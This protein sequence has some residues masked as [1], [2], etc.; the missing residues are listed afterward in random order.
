MRRREALALIAGMIVE[1]S[2]VAGAQGP[3]LPVVGILASA[4]PE[5]AAAQRNI[6]ACREALAE[7]GFVEG[8]TV[9]FEYRW[10]NAD[11]DRVPE[12]VADLVRRKVDVIVTEGATAWAVKQATST[13]P[14]V[15]HTD[16]DPVAAGLIA[17]LARPGGNLTG[18]S[19]HELGG[20][21]IELVIELVP[22]ATAIAVLVNPKSVD[23][24][25]Q[26]RNAQQAA[27]AKHL[28]LN[29]VTASNISDF[30]AAFAT[31]DRSRPDAL[32]VIGD[33]LFSGH[34][35]EIITAVARLQIPTIYNGQ[36]YVERGG[37]M[38]Y[39]TLFVP[40][41]RRKGVLAAKILKGAKPADLPV[42][43][44]DS[45]ELIINLTTAKALGLTVPPALLL[46]VDK[47]IE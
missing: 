43:Q 27:S 42:E 26:L 17:S 2:S 23:A 40:M 24:Q 14:V 34:A 39:G 20:K 22:H 38:S 46:R 5:N 16:A 21:R 44:A 41:Y 25:E 18:I 36:S 4:S 30:D 13:I 12:L 15:F 37:L 6:A 8:R 3:H 33:S 11:L 31:L 1:A 7:A 35:A 32:I 45:V 9:A 29:A 10:A 47:V 19:L 28:A